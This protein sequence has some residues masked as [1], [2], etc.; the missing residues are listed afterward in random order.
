MPGVNSTEL[1]RF[2]DTLN[3]HPAV[4]IPFEGTDLERNQDLN[5][6]ELHNRVRRARGRNNSHNRLCALP[7][8]HVYSVE[9]VP[10]GGK[11]GAA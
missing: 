5:G 3:K 9:A 2:R 1:E 10:L 8:S 6:L 11:E 4:A 7:C